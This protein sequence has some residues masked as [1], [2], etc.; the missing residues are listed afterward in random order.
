MYMSTAED[1]DIAISD[2]VFVNNTANFIGGAVFVNVGAL[3]NPGTPSLDITPADLKAT[4]PVREAARLV[5]VSE[6]YR[7]ASGSDNRRQPVSRQSTVSTSTE[8]Q[9]SRSGTHEQGSQ[10][11]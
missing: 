10:Q 5:S 3:T 8:A 2:S 1:Y 7:R 11:D 9:F 6:Q 4:R